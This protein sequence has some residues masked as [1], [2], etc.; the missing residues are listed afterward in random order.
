MS[1]QVKH[2]YL[3]VIFTALLS[4]AASTAGIYLTAPYQTKQ[5]IKQKNYE[6]K[7]LA[8]NEFLEKL[9]SDK[10]PTLFPIIAIEKLHYNITGDAS[11]QELEDKIFDLSKSD[12]ER[13]VFY[14]LTKHF[15]AL[16]L[17]GSETVK[18]YSD[19]M[20][21]VLLNNEYSVDWEY[22]TPEV[23]DTRNS[24][25]DNDGIKI[26]W[27]PKVSDEERAKFIILA[28]QYRELVNLL[29]SELKAST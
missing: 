20:I 6:N 5:I 18:L 12:Y 11:I 28:A 8:Y 10:S 2:Q 24:W 1:N 21:S 4:G 15:H 27:E 26:G 22:H 7:V 25:V 29:K 9:S 23:Q 14:S 3:I 13:K 17:Y 16:S 19:D